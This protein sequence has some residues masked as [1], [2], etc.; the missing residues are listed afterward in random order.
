M[1]TALAKSS[2]KGNSERSRLVGRVRGS[3]FPPRTYT[4]KMTRTVRVPVRVVQSS[5]YNTAAFETEGDRPQ[6]EHSHVADWAQLDMLPDVE[7]TVTATTGGM[8][9]D[10]ATAEGQAS[11]P[12]EWR[13]RALRL[14]AEMDNYRR[15]QRR[16]AQDQVEEERER[17][18]NA[19]LRIVDDL[20]RA[21]EAPTGD[22]E[23]LRQGV[24]LTHR[25][26]LQLLGKEGVEQIQ[27]KGQPFDPEWHEAIAAAHRNGSQVGPN[28]VVQVMESGYR[29]GDRLL[30]PAKV[31][32]AL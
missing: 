7:E 14:Q 2:S 27:A 13:D 28:T 23:G 24:E 5:E 16:L 32:V 12:E 19:F 10:S 3:P 15:R 9:A 4:L 18:L 31:I 30:R 22:A 29:L 11:G 8:Q 21:L 6:A 17:L 26:A 25:A 1:P 20:E